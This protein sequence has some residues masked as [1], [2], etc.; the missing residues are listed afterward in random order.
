MNKIILLFIA[1]LTNQAIAISVDFLTNSS[2]INL[3][4]EYD[5]ELTTIQTFR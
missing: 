5:S 1:I 3:Q 2:T 4:P